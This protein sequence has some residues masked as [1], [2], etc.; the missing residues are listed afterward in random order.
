MTD[1]SYNVVM[2]RCLA[3]GLDTKLSIQDAAEQICIAEMDEYTKGVF[4]SDMMFRLREGTVY[5][6]SL[7]KYSPV[8]VTPHD[9]L[10]RDDDY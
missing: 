9:D 5:E 6:T 2:R 7:A 10:L 4:V 1:L 8:P 3:A